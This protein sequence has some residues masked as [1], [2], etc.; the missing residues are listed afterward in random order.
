MT[1]LISHSAKRKEKYMGS[2]NTELSPAQGFQQAP[3]TDE[4]RL[5]HCSEKSAT[6]S[7]EKT[8]TVDTVGYSIEICWLLQFLLKPLPTNFHIQMRNAVDNHI[9]QFYLLQ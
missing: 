1:P 7:S 4:M 8:W 6:F 9:K 5:L 2:I 3:T